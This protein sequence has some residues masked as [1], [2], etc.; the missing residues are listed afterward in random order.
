MVRGCTGSR[1]CLWLGNAGAESLDAR[2][3]IF[4]VKKHVI[5]RNDAHFFIVVI[6]VKFTSR[7]DWTELS[8]A[9]WA[10]VEVLQSV[11]IVKLF[12]RWSGAFVIWRATSFR[13][14]REI[15]RF[16]LTFERLSAASCITA[17]VV[18]GE[19]RVYN[20]W[21]GGAVAVLELRVVVVSVMVDT[22]GRCAALHV[23]RWKNVL[24][25]SVFFSIKDRRDSVLRGMVPR[26]AGALGDTIRYTAT[27]LR[28]LITLF[29]EVTL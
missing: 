12:K 10:P 14:W 17:L 22:L 24:I 27:A 6:K 4:T 29:L 1:I 7:S 20:C 9:D 26:L 2:L 21:I 23:A 15:L 3:M 11:T 28:V 25:A 5:V 18:E 8:H 19:D 16:S 13:S